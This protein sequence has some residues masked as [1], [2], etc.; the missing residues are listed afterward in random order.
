VSETVR[1]PGDAVLHIIAKGGI[2]YVT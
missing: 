1:H 2:C